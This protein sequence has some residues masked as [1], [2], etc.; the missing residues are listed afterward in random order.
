MSG[1]RQSVKTPR[2]P[3][4]KPN[5]SGSDFWD[6]NRIDLGPLSPESEPSM[7]GSLS[8]GPSTGNPAVTMETIFKEIQD[9][10]KNMVTKESLEKMVKDFGVKLTDTANLIKR[11]RFRNI[12]ISG[13]PES[14]NEYDIEKMAAVKSVIEK[15]G[16]TNVFLDDVFR[17][18]KPQPNKIRPML[19]KFC[20]TL[21]KRAV[22]RGAAG[23]KGT[24]IYVNNDLT[25]DEQATE[26]LLRSKLKSLR[27]S[28]STLNGKIRNGRLSTED[29]GQRVTYV[30]REG[31]VTTE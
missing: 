21:D 6:R 20:S 8:A 11:D 16:V 14:A 3:K 18:G 7:D 17:L 10:K 9:M 1:E 30:V 25:K 19:V 2:T 23:L 4:S 26:K 22:L 15:C 27:E 13:I 12:V 5:K 24:G 29:K 31:L 28:S